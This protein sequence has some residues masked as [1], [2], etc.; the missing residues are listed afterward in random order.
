MDKPG[1]GVKNFGNNMAKMS[2]RISRTGSAPIDLSAL[3]ITAFIECKVLAFQL[4]AKCLHDL[5]E[6]KPKSL[7]AD[8]IIRNLKTK[9]QY[10]KYQ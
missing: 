5:V 6:S 9:L 1:Q 4:K 3:V 8:E 10:L 7:S 2:R